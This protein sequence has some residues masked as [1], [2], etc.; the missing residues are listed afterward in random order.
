[1]SGLSGR[2]TRTSMFWSG[3]RYGRGFVPEVHQAR[4]EVEPRA[5]RFFMG[6]RYGKRNDILSSGNIV[7]AY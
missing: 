1:M 7:L 4:L 2:S 5:D 3:S 6:S